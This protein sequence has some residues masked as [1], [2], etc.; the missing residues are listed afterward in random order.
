MLGAEPL[1]AAQ[2]QERAYV[3]SE[4]WKDAQVEIEDSQTFWGEFLKVFGVDRVR[5][6]RFEPRVLVFGKR[7]RVDLL[8]AGVLL[9]EQ[10]SKGSD[11]DRAQGQAAEYVLG[12]SAKDRPKFIVVSDF[13]RIRLYDLGH[14][15]E[16]PEE[17]L[18]SE[19]HSKV[20]LFDFMLGGASQ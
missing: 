4:R 18:L 9:V 14:M 13:Q 5:V 17:F 2:I 11:L 16:K 8:W 6:A 10:K 15:E 3:F 1:T 19:L 12:L 20:H 7:G